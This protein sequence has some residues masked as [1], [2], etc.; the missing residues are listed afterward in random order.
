MNVPVT[1]TAHQFTVPNVAL[2]DE[3]FVLLWDVGGAPDGVAPSPFGVVN[4]DFDP[5][6]RK[7]GVLV[8]AHVEHVVA[9]DDR[10]FGIG[11]RVFLSLHLRRL[12]VGRRV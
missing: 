1:A 8:V 2:T 12:L 11:V 3:L 7:N 6:R 5:P 9:E 10:L 4:G